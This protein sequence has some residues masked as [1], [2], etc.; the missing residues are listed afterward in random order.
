MDRANTYV[1]KG[2]YQIDGD[3]VSITEIPPNKS[4]RDYKT[5]LQERIDSI[6]NK[7]PDLQDIR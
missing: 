6:Q 4:V 7:D 5:F 1:V 2:E 3:S